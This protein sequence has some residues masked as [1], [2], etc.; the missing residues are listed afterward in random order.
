MQRDFPKTFW[1]AEGGDSDYLKLFVRAG[2]KLVATL[3][4]ADL[5]VFT[6]GWD[7]NPLLYGEAPRD[8]TNYC[9]DRD[10]SDI[11]A[12]RKSEGKW[13]VGICRGGQFLNVMNGGK[14]WQDVNNHCSD[15]KLVDAFTNQEVLVTSTH[16]QMFRPGVGNIVVATA[17]EATFKRSDMQQWRIKNDGTTMDNW[18]KTDYEVLYYPASKSLCFQ[19]HPEFPNAVACREYFYSCLRRMIDGTFE[20]EIEARMKNKQAA[21]G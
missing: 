7:V 14:L 13:R 5:C 20:Q 10:K 3:D 19:P 18:L 1:M 2:F 11:E 4:E 17:R 12:F 21:K 6:G 8:E 16:H 15:H 9:I